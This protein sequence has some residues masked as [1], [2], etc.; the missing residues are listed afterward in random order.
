MYQGSDPPYIVNETDPYYTGGLPS[1][2]IIANNIIDTAAEG[3]KIGDTMGN[4]FTGNVSCGVRLVLCV[5]PGLGLTLVEGV[6]IGKTALGR[7]LTENLSC[8]VRLM[9]RVRSGLGLT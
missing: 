7:E 3:I 9:L 2:N 1:Y 4:E 6:E 5:R 8:S